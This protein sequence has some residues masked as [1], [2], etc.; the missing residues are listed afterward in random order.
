MT[1]EEPLALEQVMKALDAA[2]DQVEQERRIH[3]A[4]FGVPADC[5]WPCSRV[6]HE[7][8][9]LG[10]AWRPALSIE[11][12]ERY[13]RDL[14]YKQYPGALRVA[15]PDAPL[16]PISLETAIRSR[17]SSSEFTS[18][19]LALDE[20]ARL[21]GVG[22]GVTRQGEIPKRAAPSGGALYPIET[23][24]LAF[25]IDDLSPGVYHYLPLEHALEHVRALPGIEV[26]RQFL[27]PGLFAAQPALILALTA[28]FE[29]SQLKYLERG[30]RFVL[31]E[32]GHLAQNF[33]LIA[34][35]AGLHAVPVG[36]F[37]DEPFNE[38][39]G[40]DPAREA[41]IYSVLVGHG[42]SGGE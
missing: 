15:L 8:S 2:R 26:A 34:A 29:R 10:P 38:T 4:R 41:V 40:L 22:A 42:P 30:Y 18:I 39:L 19:P 13:T 17:H 32:A 24:V 1:K 28:V 25:G 35:A 20:L 3:F 9:A 12:V 23:Y 16:P 11:E 27:P 36:G 33:L 21:L 7:Q 31:L 6:Y 37:W 5:L 14:N